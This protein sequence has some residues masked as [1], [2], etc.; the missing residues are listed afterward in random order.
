MLN[1]FFQINFSYVLGKVA[2]KTEQSSGH[3]VIKSKQSQYKLIIPFMATVLEGALKINEAAARFLTTDMKHSPRNLTILN[4]FK[5]AVAIN[6]ISLLEE[7]SSYF[8]VR[9]SS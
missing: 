8:Q 9:A 2:F 1:K 7:A 5:V 4:Q 6:N 3:I